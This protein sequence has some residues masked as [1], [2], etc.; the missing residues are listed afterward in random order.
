MTTR[1]EALAQAAEWAHRAEDAETRRTDHL[2]KA[3]NAARSQYLQRDA[4]RHRTE[5]VTAETD[6]RT[7]LDMAAM[8]TALGAALPGPQPRIVLT[9]TPEE[10]QP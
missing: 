5:A 7:A 2:L 9:T 10:P 4:Q 3:A 6:R 8:W 1:T